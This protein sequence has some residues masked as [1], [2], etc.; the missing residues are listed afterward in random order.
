MATTIDH[1]IIS[2]RD[3]PTATEEYSRL[4]GRSP[5]WQ[6]SHPDYGTANTLFQLDNVYICLLY[7]SPS[8]R[9]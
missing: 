6:G 4:L 3:L 2:V 8:P 9:D 7:T 5:S 1:I